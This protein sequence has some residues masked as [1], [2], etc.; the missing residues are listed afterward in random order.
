MKDIKNIKKD[1]IVAFKNEISKLSIEALKSL[2]DYFVNKLEE[3]KIKRTIEY[4]Q[5]RKYYQKSIKATYEGGADDWAKEKCRQIKSI[6][7]YRELI[8]NEIACEIALLDNQI[9]IKEHKDNTQKI[10]NDYLDS[11]REF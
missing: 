4:E 6:L 10:I 9:I 5:G 7:K 1:N 2:K 8:I 11:I 3:H